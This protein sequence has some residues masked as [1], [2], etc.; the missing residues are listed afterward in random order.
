MTNTTAKPIDAQR[1]NKT[2]IDAVVREVL[3][4]LTAA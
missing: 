1:I 3:A 2:L 4:R